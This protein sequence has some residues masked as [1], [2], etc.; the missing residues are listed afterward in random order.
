MLFKDLDIFWYAAQA[1][2]ASGMCYAGASG[3]LFNCCPFDH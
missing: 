1:N 3:W 2:W